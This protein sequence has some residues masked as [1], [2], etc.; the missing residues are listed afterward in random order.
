MN[1]CV[2]IAIFK[3]RLVFRGKNCFYFSSGFNNYLSGIKKGA[4]WLNDKALLDL[5]VKAHSVQALLHRLDFFFLVVSCSEHL[6]HICKWLTGF[7]PAC[8]VF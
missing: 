1:L 3:E 7:P 8:W 2:M 5:H 4:V 6:S